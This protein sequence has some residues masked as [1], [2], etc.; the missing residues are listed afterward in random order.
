V[1][2]IIFV[3]DRYSLTS[4]GGDGKSNTPIPTDLFTNSIGLIISPAPSTTLTSVPIKKNTKTIEPPAAVLIGIPSETTTSTPTPRPTGT[5]PATLTPGPAFETPFGPDQSYLLHRVSEGE[6]YAQIA[7][8]Y[9]TSTEVL[10]L[11]NIRPE[12]TKLIS[13]MIIVVLPGVH[14]IDG[15]EKFIIVFVDRRTEVKGLAEKYQVDLEE[16]QKYNLLSNED[17]IPAGRWL[18]IPQYEFK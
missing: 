14:E 13:G 7:E 11:S 1:T 16:I 15:T 5:K 17:W 3:K 12:S 10:E 2:G 8:M 9:D 4:Y 6:S 18:I